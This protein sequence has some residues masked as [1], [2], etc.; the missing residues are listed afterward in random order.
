MK[1]SLSQILTILV[2]IVTLTACSSAPAEKP[3][4]E[5]ATASESTS[6]VVLT[7]GLK[8][9]IQS[10]D[11]G[12]PNA[13]TNAN[14]DWL[15]YDR[16]VQF[17]NDGTI[18]PRLWKEWSYNDDGTE[19]Y[20]TLR[21]GVTFHNGEPFT[22]ESM[23]VTLERMATDS[24]LL[25]HGNWSTLTEVEITDDLH[26]TLKFS[27]PNGNVLNAAQTQTYVEPKAFAEMGAE[28]Y[29]QKPVGCGLFQFVSWQPNSELVYERKPDYKYWDDT[30]TTNVDRVVIKIISEDTT[31]VAALETGEIDLTNQIPYELFP[32]VENTKD[33]YLMTLNGTRAYWIGFN[34][35]PDALFNDAKAREA[36][37]LSIDRSL[38]ASTIYGNARP[39]NWFAPEGT[40]GYDQALAESGKYYQYDVEKAKG[41]LEEIGYDGTPIRVVM[42]N[43]TPKVNELSQALV[44]MFE[45]VGFTVKLDMIESGGLADRR[46]SGDFDL[47]VSQTGMSPDM[48]AFTNIQFV[49]DRIASK[50]D[51]EELNQVFRDATVALDPEKRSEF[52]RKGFQLIAEIH[53]PVIPVFVMDQSIGLNK[54]VTGFTTYGDSIFDYRNIQVNR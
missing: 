17:E 10:L 9:D 40:N 50:L 6:P 16:L 37:S 29:F 44:Y 49:N 45:T 15:M 3:S 5:N 39:A 43:N 47:F 18:T 2:L 8:T 52:L 34:C 32:T 28:A 35:R 41:I 42:M 25:M 53:G 13:V 26:F 33:A 11:V 23:K 1:R 22:S 24:T 7:I 51:K 48:S 46:N 20:I 38:I 14:T 27:E 30:V 36:I 4:A 12:S 54:S 31:R 19:W 21:E